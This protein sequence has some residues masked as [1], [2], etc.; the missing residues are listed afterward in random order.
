METPNK[1]L[2]PARPPQRNL[3]FENEVS[4]H[5]SAKERRVVLEVLIDLLLEASG[6]TGV[7][8]E[9]RNNEC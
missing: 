7:R 2:L 4:R 5:L 9:G 8:T 6:Q 3:I 1:I